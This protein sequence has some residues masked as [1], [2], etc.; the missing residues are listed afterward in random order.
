MINM[1]KIAAEKACEYVENGMIVGLGTGSTAY[2]ATCR[3]GELVQ[4]GMG[5]TGVATSKDT[6]KL[7]MEMGIPM[8]SLDEVKQID[9]TIDGA[10]EVDDGLNGIKG[11]GGA[12]LREKLVASF[13]RQTSWIIDE[14]KLVAEIG[15][16][17]L[18]VEV[19]PFGH[20]QTATMLEKLTG[21]PADLRLRGDG[22]PFV[23]DNQHFI[24]DLSIGRIQEPKRLH[25]ALVE[26]P[27]VVETGLFIDMADRVIV[28]RADGT[29]DV[30][31]RQDLSYNRRK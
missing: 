10:D 21:E 9:L 6:E 27:G 22:E 19:V 15:Q 20:L 23:T 8:K 12:L 4:Q 3:L 16:F 1:K 30:I 18:P 29:V 11:G 14:S 31:S 5:L 13:S 25:A 7:A 17:P 24:Y 2:Y 28:G 26:L